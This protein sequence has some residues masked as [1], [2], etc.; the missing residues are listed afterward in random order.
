MWQCTVLGLTLAT[1]L[2]LV[3]GRLL[4]PVLSLTDHIAPSDYATIDLAE[5]IAENMKANRRCRWL[6]VW[7]VLVEMWFW[8]AVGQLTT[9]YKRNYTLF[10]VLEVGLG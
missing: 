5:R 2:S 10:L 9:S 3:V 8:L 4:G 1:L 6:S 7:V